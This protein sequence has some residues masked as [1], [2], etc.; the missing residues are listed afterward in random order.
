MTLNEKV[1]SITLAVVFIGSPTSDLAD[2]Y[3]RRKKKPP[4]DAASAGMGEGSEGA[5]K[6]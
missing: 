1:L 6:P 2:R 5:E 3:A 4:V